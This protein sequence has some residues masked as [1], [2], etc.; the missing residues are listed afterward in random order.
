MET[1]ARGE[2][3]LNAWSAFVKDGQLSRS[4][5]WLLSGLTDLIF[6]ETGIARY[7]PSRLADC[8]GISCY[9]KW[10]ENVHSQVLP[11]P[12]VGALLSSEDL[13][14]FE[15]FVMLFRAL[16]EQI[17][18]PIPGGCYGYPVGSSVE[19]MGEAAQYV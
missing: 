18:R 17:S 15:P 16:G 14:C 2:H 13:T 11:Q 8:E 10:P 19:K 12:I 3:E 4:R 7:T 9:V 1:D 5:P 6:D